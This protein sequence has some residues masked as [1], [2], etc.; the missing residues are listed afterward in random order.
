MLQDLRHSLR[1]IARAKGTTAVLLLSLALGTGTNAAVYGVLDALL[2]RGPAGVGNPSRVVEL[3]TTELSG[4]PYG[5]SSYA[6][7]ESVRQSARTLSAIAATDDSAIE[8][9]QLGESGANAR[10]VAVSADFFPTLQLQPQ[11]GRLLGPDDVNGDTSSAVVSDNLAALIG[12]AETAVGKSLVIRDRTYTVVG[13][14]PPLFRGL[15][16]GRESDA[17]IPMPSSGSSARGDRRLSLIARLAPGVTIQDAEADLR[18]VSTDLA[19]QFPETNRGTVRDPEAVRV[20][21]PRRY[22]PLDPSSRSAVMIIAAIVAGASTLLLASACFNVG[23]LLLS[24]AVARRHEIAI[25]MALGADRRRLVRQL[26]LETQCLSLAG[27]ALGVIFAIWTAQAIP[28]LFIG[29]QAELL[30]TGLRPSILLLTIVVA[31]VSGAVFGIAPALHGSAAQA[32]TALRADAGGVSGQHVGRRLRAV[33]VTAQVAL[34]T[35]LLL[36]TGMLVM[37][38]S[39]ALEGDRTSAIKNVASVSLELP[40]RFI[41]TVPGIQFRNRMLEA[42]PKLPG[43]EAAAWANTLPLSRGNRFSF[44][45]VGKSEDVTDTLAFETNVVSP[46]YF[47]VL[48]LTCVEGRLFDE[49]DHALAPPVAIVD[50]LLARRYFGEAAVGHHLIGQRGARIEIIGVVRS[51]AYRTLQQTPQP[52]VY[53]SS[54]QDYLF[55][56]HLLVRTSADPVPQLE[57]IERTVDAVGEGEVILGTTTVERHVSESLTIDRLTTTL[58]GMCGL[59]ALAMATIGVYGTMADAVQRRTREIGLRVALGA[60]RFQV[61]KLIV[62]EAISLAFSGILIGIIAAFVVSR[63]VD[64]F[65]TPVPAVDWPSLSAATAALAIAVSIA[66]IVPLRRALSVSPMIALRAE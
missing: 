48:R 10:V 21:S 27:G 28:S 12:G 44:G 64:A 9:V 23:N 46:D 35:V 3:H 36:A 13:V 58:V 33:L 14:A 29:E 16:S 20:I 60:G 41:D 19:A 47:R 11:T 65:V 18:R 38:L 6:D 24:W 61:A 25:K 43:V 5:Q 53:F 40:G 45:L 42:I 50:E 57:T 56:G 59:I 63:F 37:S 22:S 4:L 26:V 7:Y 17:W 54:T 66:S 15:R 8:N 39:R 30:D 52:T 55:R 51:G 62:M 31:C 2:L 49:R 1:A 32:V 34:S